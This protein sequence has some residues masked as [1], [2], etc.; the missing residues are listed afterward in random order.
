MRKCRTLFS[1]ALVVAVILTLFGCSSGSPNSQDGAGNSKWKGQNIEVATW[2]DLDFTEDE[3]QNKDS[4]YYRA[5]IHHALDEFCKANGCTW[6]QLVT[7]DTS[8]LASAVAAKESPTLYFGYMQYPSIAAQN[9]LQPISSYHDQITKKYGDQWIDLSEYQGEYYSVYLPWNEYYM[10]AYDRDFFEEQG[11][12]TPRTYFEEGNWN[13]DTFEQVAKEVSRDTNGDGKKDTLGFASYQFSRLFMNSIKREANGKLSIVLD[14]PRNRAA[15]QIM[16]DLYTAGALAIGNTDSLEGKDVVMNYK[17]VDIYDLQGGN[18]MGMNVMNKN[19]HWLEM[20][21]LPKW[22]ADDTE[23]TQ[24]LNFYQLGVFSGADL[25]LGMAVMDYILEAGVVCEMKMNSGYKFDYPGLRGTTEE[26]KAYL[27]YL[28]QRNERDKKN[29]TANPYYDAEYLAS[30]REYM[31]GQK[32]RISYSYPVP[33]LTNDFT[34]NANEYSC[35]WELPPATS[36]ATVQAKLEL[37]AKQY[38]EQYAQ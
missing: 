36:I 15:A 22:K 32:K 18:A 31:Q 21:P 38:N 9:I 5:L 37:L 24:E 25:E 3:D 17:V 8:V 34:A 1:L 29:A 28:A 11:I 30:L 33:G 12:K 23:Y 20:V 35:M 2:L 4:H 13:F 6:S 19:K 10:V 27:E 26:S 7:R 14:T 16:N